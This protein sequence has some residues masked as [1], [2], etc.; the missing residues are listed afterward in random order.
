MGSDPGIMMVLL[1]VLL[2]FLLAFA[3][4]WYIG[5]KC[6]KKFGSMIRG[7]A[8]G[9]FI[10]II[11]YYMIFVWFLKMDWLYYIITAGFGVVGL[12]GSISEKFGH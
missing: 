10:G 5:F 9:T 7:F 8:I 6:S 4:S 12:F 3:G 2:P 11:L 1:G